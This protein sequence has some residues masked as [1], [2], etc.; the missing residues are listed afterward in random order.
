[1]K[2]IV[3]ATTLLT[4][5]CTQNRAREN[6]TVK[7]DSIQSNSVDELKSLLPNWKAFQIDE[8]KFVKQ[9][10]LRDSGLPAPS[11]QKL[12]LFGGQS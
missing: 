2:A 6:L 11:D 10:E 3:L 5:G 9:S 12:Q 7:S 1:M 4:A 8:C